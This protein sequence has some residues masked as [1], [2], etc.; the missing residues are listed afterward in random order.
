MSTLWLSPCLVE[1]EELR[2]WRWRLAGEEPTERRQVD[3]IALCDLA[4]DEVAKL[5]TQ[6][7]AERT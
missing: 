2:Q 7:C 4:A 6:D 5:F 1:I 3:L